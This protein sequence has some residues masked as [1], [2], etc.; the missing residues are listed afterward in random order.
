MV[1]FYKFFNASNF[2]DFHEINNKSVV[3]SVY[4]YSK[5]QGFGGLEANLEGN[6]VFE[7][8]YLYNILPLGVLLRCYP[9]IY[10]Y[11]Y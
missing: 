9:A 3:F 4:L 10:L 2:F 6:G 5:L 11:F 1:K 7:D 8:P